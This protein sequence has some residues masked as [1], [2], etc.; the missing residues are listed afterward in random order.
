MTKSP[1]FR[2]QKKIQE[3]SSKEKS[4]EMDFFEHLAELRYR[5]IIAFSA[6]AVCS[7]IGWSYSREAF[8]FLSQPYFSAFEGYELIG[9]G[10]AEAFLLRL[11]LAVFLGSLISLPMI[12]YQIWLF[13]SPGLHDHEKKLALPFVIVTSALFLLGV[14]FCFEAVMPFAFEFFRD[15]YVAI[16]SVTPTIRIAEYLSLLLKVLIGFGL[17][18]EVPVLAFILGRLGLITDK[19]LM[20]AGRYAVV[21]IFIVSAVLTPPDVLTQLLMAGPLLILYGLSIVIVRYTG[22]SSNLTDPLEEPPKN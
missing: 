21:V 4:S 14:G 6:V 18:F 15:Q 7:V 20:G 9:T 11:K 8:V 13:V 16:G 10:P 17:I 12:F 19:T 2:E 1:D 5:L 3:N 22:R